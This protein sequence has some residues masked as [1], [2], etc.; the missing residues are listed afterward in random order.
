MNTINL[1]IHQS[2]N[3]QTTQNG[4]ISQ[5]PK[6]ITLLLATT[7]GLTQKILESFQSILSGKTQRNPELDRIVEQILHDLKQV[8]KK[9]GIE[10]PS[11]QQLKKQLGE[12]L[13]RLENAG[14]NAAAMLY[15]ISSFVV[16]TLKSS[17]AIRA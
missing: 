14:S 3:E 7:N 8:A 13:R 12:L 15:A 17:T 16:A 10:V 9:L 11:V 5:L 6:D 4:Q 1:V 2:K